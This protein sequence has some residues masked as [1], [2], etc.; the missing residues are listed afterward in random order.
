MVLHNHSMQRGK[1]YDL[2]GNELCAVE[3]TLQTTSTGTQYGTFHTVDRCTLE[4]DARLRLEFE[5]R[6][7]VAIHITDLRGATFRITN[8]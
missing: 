5:D 3:Y 2:N 6:T 4:E 1:L 8:R 7:M